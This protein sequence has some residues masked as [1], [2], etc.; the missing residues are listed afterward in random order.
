MCLS[1]QDS[2]LPIHFCLAS[3][4]LMYFCDHLGSERHMSQPPAFPGL[5]SSAPVSQLLHS[6]RLLPKTSPPPPTGILRYINIHTPGPSASVFSA[7]L[8]PLW[9][10][11]K[12]IAFLDCYDTNTS[13]THSNY[14]TLEESL[15]L[16]FDFLICK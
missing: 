8:G 9:L 1:I 11:L 5:R 2:V 4:T 7:H 13:L 15:F 14:V 16:N 6:C 10:S 3:T 12:S